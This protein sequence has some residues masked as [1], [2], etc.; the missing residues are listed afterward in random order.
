MTDDDRIKL[1]RRKILASTGAVGLA[2]AGAGLGTSAFFSDEESFGN[3]TLTVGSLDLVVSAETY[4]HG[5]GGGIRAG[6]IGDSEDDDPAF[7]ISATDVKPGDWGVAQFCFD[8][9]DNPAYLWTCGTL[10]ENAENGI[11]EPESEVDDE[12]TGA[13][14]GELADELQAV[15]FHCPRPEPIVE[16][17]SGE[18]E[19]SELDEDVIIPFDS[20]DPHPGDEDTDVVGFIDSNVGNVIDNGSL[21]GVLSSM[22][23]GL[24]LDSNPD[25]DDR[26][27]YP[28]GVSD[29]CL[30][31]LLY[32]PRSTGNEVQTDRVGFDQTFHAVQ[33]RHNDGATNPC[34][35]ESVENVYIGYEDQDNGD[36]DY[37]DF[38]MEA[39]I[40][41]AY[42]DDDDLLA[43]DMTFI[44]EEN[45][46]GDNH[47]IHLERQFDSGVTYQYEISRPNHTASGE[48]DPEIAG[49]GSGTLD[50]NLFDTADSP[51]GNEVSVT[52]TITNGTVTPPVDSPRD[53]VEANNPLFDVYDPWLENR[54]SDNDYD[55]ET[56]HSDPGVFEDT[57]EEVPAII[58]VPGSENF[59]P[60][61]EGVTIDDDYPEFDEYYQNLDSQYADWFSNPS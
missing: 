18:G 23:V 13:W 48:E 15:L 50:I 40:R 49:S 17:G 22:S 35:T 27:P 55:I 14:A 33:S 10:T 58:V 52:V 42:N 11:T 61:S 47:T 38:G 53:D 34:A 1:T 54:S 5:A 2:G 37:N 44:A 28:A 8:I 12:D 32:L 56:M 57:V 31:L 36:F 16:D 7:S 30:C 20:D 26:A 41:E 59:E 45:E 19:G 6:P 60:P 29:S 21:G 39:T 51:V 43:I 4:Y 24:P 9:D 25:S 46:A 3:N